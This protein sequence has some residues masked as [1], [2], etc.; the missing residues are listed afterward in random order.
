[1]AVVRSDAP[2]IRLATVD[3][4]GGVM[5]ADRSFRFVRLWVPL[6][7]GFAVMLPSDAL[8]VAGDL[9]PSFGSKGVVTLPFASAYAYADEVAIQ[10]DRKIVVLGTAHASVGVA[11]D[12]ALVRLLP[13]GD[14]DPTFGDEGRVITDF[15]GRYDEG[16]ALT[17]QDNGKIVAAGSSTGEAAVARYLPDGTLD[18]TFD[19]DGTVRIGIGTEVRARDVAVQANGK[20]LVALDDGWTFSAA[21]LSKSGRPDAGFGGDGIVSVDPSRGSSDMVRTLA[22]HGRGFLL[23]GSVLAAGGTTHDDWGLARFDARGRID[24]S[25]GDDGLTTTDFAGSGPDVL[26]D[27]A[28]RSDGTIVAAGQSSVDPGG[29]DQS[30]DVTVALYDPDGSLVP[31]FGSGGWTRTDLGSYFDDG[32]SVA[33]GRSD[34]IVVASDVYEDANAQGAAV[35][36]TAEGQPD[37]T[38]G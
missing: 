11:S 15:D 21:R 20:I 5:H 29:A 34:T 36:F 17:L 38:F 16:L 32:R 30:S 3:V 35:R 22:L 18:R 4:R 10:A 13:N 12:F 14:L 1:M 23:G 33:L 37:A 27:L 26:E 31:S 7:F 6:V 9:D 24:R 19:G 28:V 25:F 2:W 8:G